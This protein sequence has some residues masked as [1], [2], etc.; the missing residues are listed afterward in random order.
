MT[1]N[2]IA[3]IPVLRVSDAD[4]A[5][6]FYCQQLGFIKVWEYKPGSPSPNPAYIGLQREGVWLHLSSFSGDGVF[7]NVV[8]IQVHDVDVL[9]AEFSAKGMEIDLAPYDQSWGS[10]EMYL[11]DPDHNH[12]RFQQLSPG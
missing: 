2:L 12:L 4:R 5:E 3:S 11:S 1:K 7:G 8:L 6:A 10:R 9:F